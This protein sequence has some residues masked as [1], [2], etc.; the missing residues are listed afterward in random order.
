MTKT[1]IPTYAE[2]FPNSGSMLLPYQVISAFGEDA[3]KF[4]QGQ[5]SCDV[6]ELK[7]GEVGMGTANTPKGRIYGLFKLIRVDQGFLLR[8]HKSMADEVF[9]RLSKYKVFFKCTLHIEPKH[10]VFGLIKP[11]ISSETLPAKGQ[12]TSGTFGQLLAIDEQA[13][14]FEQWTSEPADSSPLPSRTIDDWSIL[15]CLQGVPEIYPQTCE[16]FILQHLNL[17]ELGAV[18]FNKGCYTGQEIIARMKFLGKLKKKTYR[19]STP[20]KTEAQPGTPLYD[21]NGAKCGEVVRMHFSPAVGSIGLALL[22]IA[23]KES[24]RNGIRVDKAN[25]AVYQVEPIQY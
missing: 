9:S 7:D 2:L 5:L 24:E 13:Q 15:E 10:K 19:I 12:F 22:P 11:P 8:V 16:S 23:E 14:L 1:L 4:L 18:S 17:H 20:N 3:E 6:S 21:S 25:E